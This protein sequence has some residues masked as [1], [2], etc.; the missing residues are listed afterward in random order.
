MKDE[1]SRMDR[2]KD[3]AKMIKTAIRIDNRI[4]K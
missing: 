4:Y 1:I 3:L 2:F